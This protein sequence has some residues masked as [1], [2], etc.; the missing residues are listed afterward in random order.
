MEIVAVWKT[1]GALVIY[2]SSTLS[3]WQKEAGAGN[4]GG[5][6]G[7]ESQYKHCRGSAC[8]PPST[9]STWPPDCTRTMGTGNLLSP[10]S[11]PVPV[12]WL[13]L[14]FKDGYFPSTR[15]QET[16]S[17]GAQPEKCS[18]GFQPRKKSARCVGFLGDSAS[19]IS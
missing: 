6:R 4:G 1:G 9:S 16:T 10:H 13:R 7:G 17:H 2:V 12:C 8:L 19:C 14:A 5:R 15:S 11:L 3:M 18:D